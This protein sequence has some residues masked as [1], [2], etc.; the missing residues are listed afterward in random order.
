[1]SKGKRLTLLA[2][3][4]ITYSTHMTGKNRGLS[5]SLIKGMFLTQKNRKNQNRVSHLGLTS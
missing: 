1:M 2:C 5:I 3:M 4:L